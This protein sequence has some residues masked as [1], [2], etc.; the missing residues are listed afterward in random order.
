MLLN[1]K[2]N[3]TQGK[4]NPFSI[5]YFVVVLFILLVMKKKS[6][7]SAVRPHYRVVLLVQA[8][9]NKPLYHLYR[10]FILAYADE[11]P[12]VKVYFYYG[13]ASPPRNELTDHD[14]VFDFLDLTTTE[15]HGKKIYPAGFVNKTVLAM[16]EV[17]K[18]C[19]F[20]YLVRS[21]LSTFWNFKALLKKINALPKT[22]CYS[23]PLLNWF[24]GP[25]AAGFAII[26]RNDLVSA[27][28]EFPNEEMMLDRD[29]GIPEDV[30]FGIQ[31]HR[32]Y[33]APLLNSDK[34]EPNGLGPYTWYIKNYLSREDALEN[35]VEALSSGAD[36]IRMA[37]GHV[38]NLPYQNVLSHDI[39]YYRLLLQLVYGKC[40]P[41][42]T[43]EGMQLDEPCAFKLPIGKAEE[44]RKVVLE[45]AKK[46]YDAALA[47]TKN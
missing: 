27:I 11:E 15:L 3:V 38:N 39:I 45:N 6:A 42:V 24:T 2:T 9:H 7:P 5:C 46:K 1:F 10:Q 23:G 19:T 32:V 22:M 26:L 16:R 14:I 30:N 13:T 35:I 12:S 8:S 36:H 37:N 29:F 33:G 43:D 31:I 18:R 44:I 17:D 28:T 34:A 25:P 4:S 41:M 21:N 20:D 47:A 40:L